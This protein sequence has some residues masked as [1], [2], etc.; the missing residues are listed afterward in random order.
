MTVADLP[1]ICALSATIHQA[2]PEDDEIFAERLRL[3]PDGCHVYSVAQKIAAYV[4]SHPWRAFDAPPLNSLLR[5]LPAAPSTYYIHDLA[6]APQT[7]GTGAATWIVRRLADHA[8]VKEFPAMSLVAVNGSSGFWKRQG[9]A[10]ADV[11]AL[12]EKLRS[13]CDDGAQFMVRDLSRTVRTQE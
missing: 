6:L 2:Y 11:P 13:Y 4:V 10:Q 1:A 7:R 9:F 5:R 8:I 12:A 3:Y